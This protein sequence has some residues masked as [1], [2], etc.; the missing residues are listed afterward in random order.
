MSPA[1][2][3][4]FTHPE[5]GKLKRPDSLDY[6][7]LRT[8]VIS[9]PLSATKR[10]DR[11]PPERPHRGTIRSRQPN[12]KD[13][14]LAHPAPR[15]PT[16]PVGSRSAF[17]RPRRY[18][19]VVPVAR[20]TPRS[21]IVPLFDTGGLSKPVSMRSPSG[22]P[23]Q[24]GRSTLFRQS[25]ILGSRRQGRL[26]RP[27]VV[28]SGPCGRRLLTMLTVLTTES[29]VSTTTQR[30]AFPSARKRCWPIGAA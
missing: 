23:L 3:L 1:T 10:L 19:P 11:G 4:L 22:T 16:R 20:G 8:G 12:R 21:P 17:E 9:V 29:G 26:C 2:P 28:V 27:W 7:N 18:R 13:A 14:K 25:R 30:L 24:K 5:I 6:R 15:K